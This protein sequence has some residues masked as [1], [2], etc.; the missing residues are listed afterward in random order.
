MA[1]VLITTVTVW[2][3]WKSRMPGVPS[4]SVRVKPW[5]GGM[6]GAPSNHWTAPAML[7]SWAP[8]WLLASGWGRELMIKR[9]FWLIVAGAVSMVSVS[10]QVGL[11]LLV[12]K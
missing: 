12:G 4:V 5:R 1:S 2:A 10:S 11:L 9:W 7:V 8:F 6:L 3:F